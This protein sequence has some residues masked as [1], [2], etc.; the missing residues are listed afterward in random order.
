MVSDL[1]QFY[2]ATCYRYEDI[3]HKC[4]ID[5]H[6]RAMIGAGFL[7]TTTQPEA[8]AIVEMTRHLKWAP[9]TLAVTSRGKFLRER[10]SCNSKITTTICGRK[11]TYKLC[12][13][14]CP[15]R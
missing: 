2:S 4:D 8:E 6:L 14:G 15:K 11:K 1:I 10:E 5:S 3:N 13:V 7:T 9:A 12:G